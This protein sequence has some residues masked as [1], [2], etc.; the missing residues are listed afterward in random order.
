MMIDL[1]S[2]A[3]ILSFDFATG[4]LFHLSVLKYAEVDSLISPR[5]FLRCR[6]LIFDDI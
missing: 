6:D 4:K 2:A 3:D 1:L 5:H